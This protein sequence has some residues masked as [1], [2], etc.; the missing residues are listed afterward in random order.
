MATEVKLPDVLEG[1]QDVTINRWLVKAGD[2]VKK[3]QPILE[4]ATEK[5]DTQVEA[6]ADGTILALNFGEGEIVNL[7]AVLALIGSPDEKVAQSA[8]ARAPQEPEGSRTAE[9]PVQP[10]SE[11][12]PAGAE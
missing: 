4:I 2:T 7:N 1:I 11:G 6:P 10:A 3:G 9:A 5:V 8:P 12:E